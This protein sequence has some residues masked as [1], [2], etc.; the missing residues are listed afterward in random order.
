M[1]RKS[2]SQARKD[3]AEIVNKVR[4]GNE[5][6]IIEK[7]GKE[8]V[9]II[10]II[11]LEIL[12]RIEDFIDLRDAEKALKEAEEKGTIP[13]EQVLKEAGLINE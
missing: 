13:F 3:F 10:P 12:E 11:D 1:E 8:C 5:R 9:A 4:Y 6:T 2:I 7:H